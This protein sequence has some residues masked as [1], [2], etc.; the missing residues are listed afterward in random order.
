MTVTPETLTRH[1]LLGRAV[2]VVESS[3]PTH[4]GG[5]GRV[6][7]ETK[8][9]L[10][11]ES[12]A[13]VRQLPKAVC[14]FEF[15]LGSSVDEAAGCREAPGTAFK[16]AVDTAGGTRAPGQSGVCESVAYVT[17]DGRQ[18]LSRPARR[19]EDGGHTIWR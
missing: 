19:S 18:L 3:D 11:I 9:T 7:R 8:K 10:S 4:V 5:T 13:G 6:V 12:A 14:T 1:E 16:H 17:V 2:R 15:A